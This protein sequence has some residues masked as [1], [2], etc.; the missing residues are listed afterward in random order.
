[1][2]K[3]GIALMLDAGLGVSI[4]IGA[5]ALSVFLMSRGSTAASDYQ[6]ARIGADVLAILDEHHSFDDLSHTLIE[7]RMR[8]VLPA[9]LDMLL[10]IEGDFEEG[11]G[12]IEVGGNLPSTKSLIPVRRVVLTTDNTYLKITAYVWLQ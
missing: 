10:S 3:K 1:M 2:V 5:V 8:D 4:V 7:Q 12:L 9:H 6:L 11:D